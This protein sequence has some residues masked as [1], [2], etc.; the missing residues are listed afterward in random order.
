MEGKQTLVSTEEDDKGNWM[1]FEGKQYY[2]V[3]DDEEFH[4]VI[5]N[6]IS[7]SSLITT[8]VTDMENMSNNIKNG[9]NT[10]NESLN[11]W[12]VSNVIFMRSMFEDCSV[13]NKQLDQWDVSNVEDM[14]CMFKNCELFNQPLNSWD[15]S[16]VENM[17]S[18]FQ[19]CSSFNQPLDQWNVSNVREML[20]MFEDCSSFNQP[21]KQWDVSNV[22][23]ME[24]IFDGCISFNQPFSYDFIQKY[25]QSNKNNYYSK[26]LIEYNQAH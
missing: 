24:W 5:E 8:Y 6:G 15:V 13:F 25:I 22:I 3:K 21:L 1:E 20:V 17:E 16:K 18:M 14:G 4:E 10:F 7:L 2:V 19:G 26:P 9:C 23:N 12:D 11:S